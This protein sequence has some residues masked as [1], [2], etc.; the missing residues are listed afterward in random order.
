[1]W[2]HMF[3]FDGRFVMTPGDWELASMITLVGTIGE[4]QD[5]QAKQFVVSARD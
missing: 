1:M 2:K 3:R 5:D 4:V